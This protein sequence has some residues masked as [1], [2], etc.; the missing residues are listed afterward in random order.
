LFQTNANKQTKKHF[1]LFRKGA[2]CEQNFK[3]FF[4]LFSSFFHRF[5]YIFE[6]SGCFFVPLKKNGLLPRLWR[7]LQLL[8]DGIESGSEVGLSK[9]VLRRRSAHTVFDATGKKNVQVMFI[10]TSNLF[11]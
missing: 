9:L 1:A 8:E 7:K 5:S 3:R 4:F 10:L 2:Q 11:N 6:A